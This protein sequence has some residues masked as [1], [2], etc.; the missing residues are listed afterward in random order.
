M[1]FLVNSN[2]VPSIAQMMLLGGTVTY[3]GPP[4]TVQPTPQP[5]NTNL[6]SDDF[7]ASS[8]AASGWST[9]VSGTGSS[10]SLV[11]SPVYTG[12]QAANFSTTTQQHGERAFAEHP[13]TWPASNVATARAEVQITGSS[14]QYFSKIFSFETRGPHAWAPSGVCAWSEHVPRHL[15]DRGRPDTHG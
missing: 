8:F 15:R 11:T 1:L 13:L 4:P 12:S 14:V 7:E 9:D 5:T 10:A 2:G 6:L 3:T